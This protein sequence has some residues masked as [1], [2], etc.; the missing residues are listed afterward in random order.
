MNYNLLLAST[1]STVS[2]MVWIWLAIVVVAVLIEIFTMELVSVWF[3]LGA[4]VSM[5]LAL[6]PEV[7]WPIQLV[8]FALIGII[9]ILTVRP[10]AK[11]F[12]VKKSEGKT[13]LDL[14]VGTKIRLLSKCDFDVLGTT[15]IN[16]ILWN[17]TTEDGSA[18]EEGSIALVKR[19]HGNKI[20]VEACLDDSTT[21][22]DSITIVEK[23]AENKIIVEASEN[24]QK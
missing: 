8:V 17:V 14:I 11:K 20:V 21:E 13:N 1:A 2:Y 24:E 15:K 23:V 6:F 22:E 9:A 19:V 7:T 3:A 5:I 16:G 18:I 4:L 10:F 12:L